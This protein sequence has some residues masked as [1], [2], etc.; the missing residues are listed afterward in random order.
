MSYTSDAIQ[1]NL[2][3][4]RQEQFLPYNETL[5]PIYEARERAKQYTLQ[6]AIMMDKQRSNN[7]RPTY[8]P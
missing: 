1:Q 5:K 7:A 2:N 4:Y 3:L 6:N 8:L